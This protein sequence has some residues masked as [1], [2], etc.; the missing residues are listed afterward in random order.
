MSLLMLVPIAN[1]ILPFYIAFA[2]WPV[3][4]QTR[5]GQGPMGPGPVR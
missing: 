2:E 3:L 4:R 1:V 5:S